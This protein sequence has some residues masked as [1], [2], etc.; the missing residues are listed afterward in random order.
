MK[1]DI[2]LIKGLKH[3]CNSPKRDL[4][5]IQRQLLNAGATKEA[6]QLGKIIGR[7]EAWQNK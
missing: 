2:E 7:L 4:M 1:I 3:E 6:E 5:D